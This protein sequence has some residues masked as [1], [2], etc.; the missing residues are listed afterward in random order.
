MIYRSKSGGVLDGRIWDWLMS[1]SRE[2]G[3]VQFEVVL[4]E[5]TA[6]L[7]SA[8]TGDGAYPHTGYNLLAVGGGSG[9]QVA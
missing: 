4:A 5:C 1:K 2:I 7:C 8:A 3:G 6:E 9:G